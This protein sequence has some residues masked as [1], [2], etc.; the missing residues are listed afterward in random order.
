MVERR[1]DARKGYNHHPRRLRREGRRGHDRR[2]HLRRRQGAGPRL[3][4]RAGRPRRRRGRRPPRLP[5]PLRAALHGHLQ[6][7]CQRGQEA[8]LR[9]E[10]A[11]DA[12]HSLLHL[13]RRLGV[14][15]P[16]D[17]GRHLHQVADRAL[18]HPRLRR[19]APPP[20][21]CRPRV[22][23]R[24]LAGRQGRGPGVEGRSRDRDRRPERRQPAQ[25][26]DA[27]DDRA[28]ELRGAERLDQARGRPRL[29]PFGHRREHRRGRDERRAARRGEPA[30]LPD[31]R[32]AARLEHPR[33]E[34][35]RR[36]GDLHLP[37]REAGLGRP[38]HGQE[39]HARARPHPRHPPRHRPAL[40][41]APPRHPRRRRFA[42]QGRGDA[43]GDRLPLARER[44][45]RGGA[46]E[47][48]RQDRGQGRLR[49]HRAR[50]DA[51]L[52]RGRAAPR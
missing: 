50:R 3:R 43:R 31:A 46:G 47:R 6:E 27:G 36:A 44:Q 1:T 23:A 4:R 5:R 10:R 11:T 19:G 42:D 35:R 38:A 52:D 12:Q 34:P 49:L 21:P 13:L 32:R 9:D 45:A 14:L 37:G 2:A 29:D 16:E 20:A 24:R 22:P 39:S 33:H 26:L 17:P 40:A 28:D 25:A 48:R 18:P 30:H 15:E 41:V 7:D 8:A 51:G